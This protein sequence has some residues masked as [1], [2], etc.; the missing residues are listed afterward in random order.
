MMTPTELREEARRYRQASAEE[1][2][3]HLKR[4][5]ASHALALAQLAEMIERDEAV[6]GFE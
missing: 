2:E 4:H 5:L 6:F 1:T 3:P